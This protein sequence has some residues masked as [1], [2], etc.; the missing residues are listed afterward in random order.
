MVHFTA[1][2][3]KKFDDK[4][5][6]GKGKGKATSPAIGARLELVQVY[7]L[8]REEEMQASGGSSPTKRVAL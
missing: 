4:A 6:F 1:K 5:S 3:Y 2:T 8:G 7:D